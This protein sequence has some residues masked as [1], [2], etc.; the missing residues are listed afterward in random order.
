MSVSRFPGLEQLTGN[1]LPNILSSLRSGLDSWH[2]Q[3]AADYAATHDSSGN[4]INVDTANN[5]VH[6]FG[7]TEGQLSVASAAS[8]TTALRLGGKVES[9]LNVNSA[10][11]A[12]NTIALNGKSEAY[13]TNATN[14]ATGTVPTARLGSGAA[15]SSTFLRGDQTW[16]IVSGGGTEEA[17]AMALALG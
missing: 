9:E 17:V 11:F 2:A 7:K 5:A 8:A 6:A 16:Q 4:L 14:L 3:F 15:N 12:S 1:N 10:L 13:Y